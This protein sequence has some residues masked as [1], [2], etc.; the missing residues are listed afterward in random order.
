MRPC[1]GSPSPSPPPSSLPSPPLHWLLNPFSTTFPSLPPTLHLSPSPYTAHPLF[2]LPRLPPLFPYPLFRFQ[3]HRLFH[4]HIPL[5]LLPFP[6]PI[7]P[8]SFTSLLP[9]HLPSPF[10]PHSTLLTFFTLFLPIPRIP[11]HFSPTPFPSFT[12]PSPSS[13]LVPTSPPFSYPSGSIGPCQGREST[14]C[15]LTCPK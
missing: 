8:S 4:P 2:T 5:T 6:L 7:P 13:V 14:R 11:Y 10:L 9:F 12:A 15:R 3:L 1:R